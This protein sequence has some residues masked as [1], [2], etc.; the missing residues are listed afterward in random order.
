MTSLILGELGEP[1]VGP[2]VLF[3]VW[4]LCKNFE[5]GFQFFGRVED[6]TTLC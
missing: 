2:F 6:Y 1:K 4:I 3:S 5:Y